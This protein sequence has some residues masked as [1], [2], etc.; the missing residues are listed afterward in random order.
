MACPLPC[1]RPHSL[2]GTSLALAP[3]LLT[4]GSG[5]H[6]QRSPR[7]GRCWK[8]QDT[9]L[10]PL[11]HSTQKC[12]DLAPPRPVPA[13]VTQ[14]AGK[15]V[16]ERHRSDLSP[17]LWGQHIPT[18]QPPVLLPTE[19]AWAPFPLP[20]PWLHRQVPEHSG[21][22]TI[23]PGAHLPRNTPTV[24][25][26]TPREGLPSLVSC[27]TEQR[28]V[29]LPPNLPL[30]LQGA[31]G[32]RG[33]MPPISQDPRLNQLQQLCWP[34]PGRSSPHGRSLALA[35]SPL[36]AGRWGGGFWSTSA[37][38]WGRGSGGHASCRDFPE[39]PCSA[40]CPARGS[41]GRYSR[42]QWLPQGR[43][44]VCPRGSPASLAM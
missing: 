39:P 35:P 21:G 11:A 14:T 34:R 13:P 44:G 40:L 43:A 2:P 7:P 4:V 19:L 15:R 36:G 32:G 16:P 3:A 23:P 9:N 42:P 30:H 1:C 27:T 25:W 22:N 26:E 12:Q 33:H 6:R 29:P 20:L 41:E 18:P 10:T 5:R 17:T 24:S 31:R 37:Q 28:P 8:S 38:P